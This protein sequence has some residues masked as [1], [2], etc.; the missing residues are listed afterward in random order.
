[1][2]RENRMRKKAML[3]MILLSIGLFF[4]NVT[5]ANA[6]SLETHE[7]QVTSTSQYETTPTLGNDGDT[8][9]VVYTARELQLDGNFR[10]ADIW[11]QELDDT[12]A[13]D[14]SPVRV[15][16]TDRD[17]QLNDISG[18]WIVY[19]SY[20]SVDSDAGQI[21][22]HQIS[23]GDSHS[24]TTAPI[25]NEVRI[26]G[27]LMVWREGDSSDSRVM[28]YDLAWIG[29]DL[30]PCIV[31][32]PDPPTFDVEIGDRFIV[33]TEL[34][35][36]QYDVFAYD[37]ENYIRIA[38]AYESGVYER[39]PKTCG[40]WI[41]WQ[42]SNLGSLVT[43]IKAKNMDTGE[44]RTV[45]DDTRGN[46]R[47]SI[48]GDFI[49][50]E[51]NNIDTETDLE[52]YLYR[53]STMET[54]RVTTNS[55]DQYLNDVFGNLVAY[56]DRRNGN[57]D[58]FVSA[59]DF[60]S[61]GD[62]SVSPLSYDFGEVDLGGSHTITVTISNVADS[63]ALTVEDIAFSSD[64]S[65]AFSVTSAP[66]LPVIISAGSSIDIV[67]SFSPAVLGHA[68]A[69]LEITS[70]DPDEPIVNV[71][72]TGHQLRA[73]SNRLVNPVVIDGQKSSPDEWAD[74]SRYDV[75]LN[76]VW[77]WPNR[78]VE[79]SD[80]VLSVRFKNDAVWLYM[81]YQ[82]EWPSSELDTRDGGFIELFSGWTGSGWSESDYGGTFLEGT[83]V[84]FYSWTGGEWFA[85]TDTGGQNNVE[86]AVSYDGWYYRIEFRKMLDSGD[87]F[88]WSL[89]PGELVGS[90]NAPADEPNL[91]V[92]VWDRYN[93][94]VNDASTYEQLISLQLSHIADIDVSPFSYDFGDVEIGASST[95]VLTITNV[96]GYSLLVNDVA[97]S[98]GG[99][100]D[101][102]IS[103]IPYLPAIV[104]TGG[105]IDIEITYTPSTSGASSA[106]LE[107]SSDDT[108]EPV[109][110][111]SFSGTGV[112]YEPPPS[113]Q[114]IRILEFFD[115]SV[116]DGTLEGDGPGM[117]AGRR[118]TALRNM[119]IAAGG[120]IA[121][122][123]LDEACEQLLA[124]YRRTDGDPQPPDFVKG[125]A[126]SELANQILALL[127]SV[128]CP[129]P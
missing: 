36:E 73:T 71:E 48:D 79:R 28:M 93:P 15:T 21:M 101:F 76:L 42:A 35:D 96:G 20:D 33:W 12:G 26:N 86:G 123:Q 102:S 68:F 129:L 10:A 107:I 106:V 56:V 6:V 8:D 18:D 128:G 91:L 61:E 87:G 14:G 37:F 114:I 83:N 23:T 11:Y 63:D 52:I 38:V 66:A 3:V 90:P 115:Q 32:G 103:Y 77:N 54:F 74:T 57:E 120:F 62:I 47:P 118:L 100:P 84:D 60:I 27:E 24:I 70:D 53:L 7:Y 67:V 98:G 1:M 126:A 64:S 25:I 2:R 88:D 121:D 75:A 72:L 80:K 22:V 99:N 78:I 45:A 46:F 34:T 5:P 16:T 95:T 109:I 89:S 19:T 69:T 30:V 97:F 117:S 13:P 104:S 82:I 124:A 17:D 125:E 119:I 111:V 39:K 112:V 105:T 44:I 40:P 51:S 59:L 122:G 108:D 65:L 31:A 55:Y 85:D 49:V 81:F 127:E 4:V 94:I 92:G 9:I 116:K 50:Y 43:T 29:S 113:E 110:M 58:V 41:V